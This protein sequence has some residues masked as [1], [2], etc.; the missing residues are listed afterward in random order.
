MCNSNA[1][2]LQAEGGHSQG[3]PRGKFGEEDIEGV[4]DG[5]VAFTVGVGQPEVIH[6]IWQHRPGLKHK[7]RR[8]ELN[9][10]VS[11]VIKVQHHSEPWLNFKL[12]RA[13]ISLVLLL[14]LSH[15]CSQDAS[16]QRCEVRAL[17]Y[18][19]AKI[20]ELITRLD[21]EQRAGQDKQSAPSKINRPPSGGCNLGF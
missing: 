12:I 2:L 8:A 9:E 18:Q 6:H 7:N 4:K 14:R 15:T 16:A 17:I 3:D 1:D 11:F 21:D 20:T 19:W 13:E 5:F 10:H